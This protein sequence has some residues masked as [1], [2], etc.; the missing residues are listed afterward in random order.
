MS[1][2][3]WA[4]PGAM[5]ACPF[6]KS[7]VTPLRRTW[8][9][10]RM[11]RIFPCLIRS[12]TAFPIWRCLKRISREKDWRI[13]LIYWSTSGFFCLRAMAKTGMSNRSAETPAISQLPEW[14]VARMKPFSSCSFMIF[15]RVGSK[16]IMGCFWIFFCVSM[17]NRRASM[18]L[19]KRFRQEI[20]AM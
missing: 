5:V 20:Q 8:M 16:T 13:L 6:R 11:A 1:W 10:G 3:K 15:C 4:A 14:G 18:A 12:M 19:K 7:T 2:A 9:S 17:G